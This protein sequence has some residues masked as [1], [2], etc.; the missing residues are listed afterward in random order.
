MGSHEPVGVNASDSLRVVFRIKEHGIE[1]RHFANV[2]GVIYHTITRTEEHRINHRH[3]RLAR[4]AAGDI[5]LEAFSDAGAVI[6][7]IVARAETD[8]NLV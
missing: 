7:A 6:V 3:K 2:R 1:Y 5:E 4:L 8:C